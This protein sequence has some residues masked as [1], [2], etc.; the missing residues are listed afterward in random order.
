MQDWQ[1]QN[2]LD[3]MTLGHKLQISADGSNPSE[4]VTFMI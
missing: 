1:K 2:Q 3:S 4:W